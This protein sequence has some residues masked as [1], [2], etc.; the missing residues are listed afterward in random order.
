MLKRMVHIL[1][2]TLLLI[3]LSSPAFAIDWCAESGNVACYLMEDDGDESNESSNGTTVLTETSGDIPQSSTKKFGTYSRDFEADDTEYFTHA[4]G[5]E[6]DISG[7]DAKLSIV[8]WSNYDNTYTGSTRVL[9][10]KYYW[11][12]KK[13]YLVQIRNGSP[14]DE[15]YFEV[16]YNSGA[17]SHSTYGASDFIPDAGGWMH[18][19]VVSNDTD[20]RVYVNGVLDNTPLAHTDGISDTDQDFF[21]GSNNGSDSYFDGLMDDVGIF[22]V[23][24]S[25]T[26]INDIM[27]FG[28]DQSV[29]GT[30]FTPWIMMF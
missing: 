18:G 9:V 1:S 7:A 15:L 28:L 3:F 29:E 4:D 16:G 6:T 12:G 13:Q 30:T 25:A 19:A 24:L 21:V 14:E 20:L 27:D 8:L 22:D 5:N 10:K 11:S 23:A 2:A 26:D 17:S